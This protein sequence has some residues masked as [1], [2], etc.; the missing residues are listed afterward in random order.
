[1]PSWI[2][3][4]KFGIQIGS[5]WTDWPAEAKC[6]ETDIKKSQICPIWGPI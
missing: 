1:M 2:W 3:D 5:D 4:V 6:N